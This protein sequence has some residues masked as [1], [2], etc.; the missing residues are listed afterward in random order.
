MFNGRKQRQDA[1]KILVRTY[2]DSAKDNEIVPSR[3]HSGSAE[4]SSLFG[5]AYMSFGKRLPTS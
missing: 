1:F 2:I 4:D 5:C 3:S